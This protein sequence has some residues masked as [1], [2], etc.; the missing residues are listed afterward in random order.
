[1]VGIKIPDHEELDAMVNI[2]VPSDKYEEVDNAIVRREHEIF[3][4]ES[5]D[6]GV[7][8]FSHSDYERLAAKMKSL[9]YDLKRQN[10][11]DAEITSGSS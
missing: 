4:T 10:A 11:M 7:R 5:Y 6:I 1:M 2:V 9:N 8:V 3:I